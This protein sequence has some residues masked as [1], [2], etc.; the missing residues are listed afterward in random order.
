MLRSKSSP[1]I[2]AGSSLLSQLTHAS[3]LAAQESAG[4]LRNP[5]LARSDTSPG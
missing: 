2:L 5:R 3:R 4:L 1:A